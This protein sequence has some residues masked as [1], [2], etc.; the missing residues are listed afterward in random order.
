MKQLLAK[1]IAIIKLRRSVALP[2][3]E[4]EVLQLAKDVC[5]LGNLPYNDSFLHAV[6][7][8]LMHESGDATKVDRKSYV[9][10]IKRS[11]ANQA[12]FGV[13]E[14][15]KARQKADKASTEALKAFNG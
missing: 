1:L 15:T 12:A 6:A 2:Q 9:V 3:T 10:A 7:S 11:I 14:D 8:H 5:V 4:A 13:I